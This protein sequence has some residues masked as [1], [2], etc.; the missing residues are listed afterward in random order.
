MDADNVKSVIHRMTA[1]ARAG[2]DARAMSPAKALRLSLSKAADDR[3]RLPL[4]VTTVEQRALR[5]DEIAGCIGQDDLIALVDSDTGARGAVLLD[6]QVL[7]ALIEQQ[8]TGRVR[9]GP[10][11]SRPLTRTDA[12]IAAPMIDALLKGHDDRMTGSIA[13]YE[14]LGL[15]F[16]DRMPDARSLCLALDG[17]R[18]DMFQI[19]VTIE[20]G[21]RTGAVTVLLPRPAPCDENPSDQSEA[22]PDGAGLAENAMSAPLVLN[23]VVARLSLPLDT[24]CALEAGAILPLEQSDLAAIRLLGTQGHVVAK[25][26]LGKLNGWRAVRFTD[27]ATAA[28]T[29]PA[30]GPDPADTTPERKNDAPEPPAQQ[31]HA[32]ESAPQSRLTAPDS[33]ATA[34][35]PRPGDDAVPAADTT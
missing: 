17:G 11:E 35:S 2:Y 15:R 34:A 32:N 33:T 5:A 7:S 13:G 16:G 28:A 6:M 26:R 9:S 1:A 29:R 19:A 30:A 8:T 27:D 22:R 25:V 24:V 4:T 12:A 23:A 31:P 21:A 3:F 14:A 20:N 10:V 18:Y